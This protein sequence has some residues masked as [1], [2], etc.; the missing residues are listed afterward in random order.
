MPANAVDSRRPRHAALFRNDKGG[1]EIRHFATATDAAR[2]SA[3]IETGP[4]PSA[5]ELQTVIG[6]R[7]GDM[8]STDFARR[9]GIHPRTV[10]RMYARR[11][12]PGARE[13]GERILLVPAHLLRL[14]LAY[15]LRHVG[16]LA[17]LGQL[18]A[19]VRR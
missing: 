11:E 5:E 2:A 19:P 18:A 10:R 8:R 17:R 9:L 12:L 1:L 4:Q 14:A 6:K 3:A 15:G 16:R 13:H 7:G